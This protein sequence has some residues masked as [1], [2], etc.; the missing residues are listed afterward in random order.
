MTE[1]LN[2]YPAA[3]LSAR[4]DFMKGATLSEVDKYVQIPK[5]QFDIQPRVI[6]SILNTNS[7]KIYFDLNIRGA[8]ISLFFYYFVR[9]FINNK[10][11]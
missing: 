7:N 1:I 3:D 11:S 9:S 8:E 4:K 2:G 6:N 10:A 5:T